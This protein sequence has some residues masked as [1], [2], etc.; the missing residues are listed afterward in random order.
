MTEDG[1]YKVH[2]QYTFN[3]FCKIDIC[4]AAIDKILKQRRRW[5][6]D[7][8][9]FHL[10]NGPVKAR[11][12]PFWRPLYPAC[13]GSLSQADPGNPPCARCRYDLSPDLATRAQRKPRKMEAATPPA[14]AVMPPV[15]APRSP[16][17][18]TASSTP[19]ARE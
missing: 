18:R 8:F 19:L 5:G 10:Q 6:R 14:V 17:S 9:P 2:I 15:S 3:A 7:S 4:H 12:G 11:G 16:C 13:R 1:A